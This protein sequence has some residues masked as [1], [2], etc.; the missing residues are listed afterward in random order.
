M[1]RRGILSLMMALIPT[2]LMA[3]GV[4]LSASGEASTEKKPTIEIVGSVPMVED[5]QTETPAADAVSGVPESFDGKLEYGHGLYLKGD[6]AGALDVYNQAKQM[7]TTDPLVLYYIACAEAK[8]GQYDAAISALNAM[9]TLSGE[10]IPSLT[11]R[12]LFFTAVVEEMRRDDDKAVAAWNAYKVFAEGHSQI[13]VFL[14]SANA[15]LT[16][17]EKKRQLYEQYEVVRQRLTVSE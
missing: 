13:P 14:G 1:F 5:V 4:S 12:A 10:K 16:V 17:L 9:K 3:Q 2:G 7:R 8:Q 15:R 6:Y 11:A